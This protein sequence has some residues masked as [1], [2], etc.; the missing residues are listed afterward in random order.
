MEESDLHISFI[1]TNFIQMY[2]LNEFNAIDYFSLSQFYDRTCNNNVVKM[3][4]RF[5]SIQELQIQMS[6]MVGIEYILAHVQQPALFVIHKRKRSSPEKVSLLESYYILEGTIYKCPT[7]YR[8]FSTRLMT[9]LY[10][11]SKAFEE[12][13]SSVSFSLVDSSY[14]WKK[15]KAENIDNTLDEKKKEEEEEASVQYYSRMEQILLPLI[16]KTL[17]EEESIFE[18]K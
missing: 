4:T 7:L 14:N 17:G 1:D 10:F 6:K 2:G 15:K 8:V 16:D 11:I 5:N 12:I 13:Q 9:S 18:N 3:Q